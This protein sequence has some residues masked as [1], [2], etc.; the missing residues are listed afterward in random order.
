VIYAIRA[1]GTEFVKIGK[2]GSV[3]RRL[4]EL[5]TGCPYELHIEAVADWPD[6]QESA[7]HEYLRAHCQKFEWFRDSELTAKVIEWLQ[8]GE[9]GLRAF[10]VAFL[11]HAKKGGW[12]RLPGAVAAEY[13]YPSRSERKRLSWARANQNVQPPVPKITEEAG[14]PVLLSAEDRAQANE[15]YEQIKRRALARKA[16]KRRQ[17][18]AS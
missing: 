5:E 16:A 9:T 14:I 7:I 6:P 3:G 1:V 4:K 11:E 12:I 13:V 8:A 15:R 2:A 18:A 10:R 17:E